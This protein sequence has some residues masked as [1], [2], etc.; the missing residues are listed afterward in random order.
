MTI[1]MAVPVLSK[2]SS[3]GWVVKLQKLLEAHD[4]GGAL[5]PLAK[6]ETWAD[7]DFGPGTAAA[8]RAWQQMRG[9]SVDGEAGPKTWQELIAG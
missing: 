9:M 8:L 3:G 7:G 1:T 2:G 4:P 6:R 5:V